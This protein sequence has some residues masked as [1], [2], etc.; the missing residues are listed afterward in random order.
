MKYIAIASLIGTVHGHGMMITPV[1][2]NA[3]DG[4]NTIGGSMWF[5][6]GCSIGCTECNVT[7]VPVPPGFPNNHVEM[8]E[9]HD[10]APRLGGALPN[11][12]SYNGDLCAKDHSKMPGGKV[13]TLPN[14]Y[15]TMPA[16]NEDL[17]GDSTECRENAPNPELCG[18]WSAWNPWRAPG[19]TPGLDPCGIAGGAWTN[20]SYR[21]GGFGPQTGHPQG[22]KGSELPPTPRSKREVWKAGGVAEVA[23]TSVANHAGGY[24]WSLCPANEP[25]TEACFER[26]YLSYSTAESK[27]RYMFMTGNGTM[28]PNHTTVTI[29]A[30]RVTEGV[31][32]QGSTWTMNPVPAGSWTRGEVKNASTWQGNQ[33][34]PQFPPPAGCDEHCWGYQPCNVGFT[35]PSYHGWNHTVPLPTC[36]HGKNGQGCCHTTA[37]LAIID[38]VKVPV[39]P[40]GDYVLRWRWD[41]EQSPQIWSNCADV[42]ITA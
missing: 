31:F 35:H 34:P 29:P 22:F 24:S 30:T 8:L 23:W 20:M 9:A 1:S 26:N 19:S 21:A 5:S 25:L 27:L 41:C 4:I 3:P 37:Y 11:I 38:E 42:T 2:R 33:E 36:A 28:S 7:G 32:P 6:Q 10:P 16:Q 17:G 18:N 39:V 13:A 40:A 12:G 15:A 14:K